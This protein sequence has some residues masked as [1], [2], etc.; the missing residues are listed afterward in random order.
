MSALIVKAKML[1]VLQENKN[2]LYAQLAGKSFW[3]KN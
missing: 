2:F 1:Q 3:L